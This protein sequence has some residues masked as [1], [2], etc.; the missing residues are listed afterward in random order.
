MNAPTRSIDIYIK[1]N[2]ERKNKNAK[3]V[4]KEK[5]DAFTGTGRKK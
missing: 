1:N 4:I 2:T 5:S 3:Y